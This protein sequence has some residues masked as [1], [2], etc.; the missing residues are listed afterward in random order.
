MD[1][2]YGK[3]IVEKLNDIIDKARDECKVIK[4][5]KLTGTEMDHLTT[6]TRHGYTHTNSYDGV[7]IVQYLTEFMEDYDYSKNVTPRHNGVR[8]EIS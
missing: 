5:I 1:I 6:I 7:P 8:H 2:V 4:Y 3:N